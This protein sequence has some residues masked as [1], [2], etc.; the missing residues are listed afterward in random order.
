MSRA[1]TSWVRLPPKIRHE[2]LSILPGLGGRCSLLATVSQ[3]WHAVIEPLNFAEI[4]LTPPCLSNPDSAAIL[5]RKRSQ[6]RHIWFCVELQQYNCGRCL[7]KNQEHWGLDDADNRLITDAFQSLFSTSSKWEPRN[8]LVLDISVYSCD[9]RHWFKYLSFH[10]DTRLGKSSSLQRSRDE[11]GTPIDDP[12]HGWVAGQQKFP[13]NEHAIEKVFNEIM[14][15]GPFEDE[16]PEM[17]WWQTL[18]LVPAVAVGLLRQQ[19]RRCWKPVALAN[20][21][22]RFPN[23]KELCYEP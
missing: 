12:T 17:Q 9:T 15:E 5:F 4:S 8:N 14:A 18:P 7:P 21:L 1:S 13:L 11:L 20:I 2:V 16:E 22:T 10:P 6:I 19:T 23:M 3:E